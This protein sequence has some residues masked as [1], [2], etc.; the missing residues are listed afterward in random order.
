MRHS[1]VIRMCGRRWWL[2]SVVVTVGMVVSD[3]CVG[4]VW[5]TVGLHTLV[6]GFFDRWV[7]LVHVVV[8]GG[9]VVRAVCMLR[10]IR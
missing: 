6:A 7:G 4:S 10:G 3:M 1:F 2:V 9:L 8:R 5:H